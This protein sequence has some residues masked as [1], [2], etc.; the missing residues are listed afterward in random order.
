MGL[1]LGRGRR[2]AITTSFRTTACRCTGIRYAS[3]LNPADGSRFAA[4]SDGRRQ[5]QLLRCAHDLLPGASPAIQS[6]VPVI[7]PVIDYNN[8]LNHNILGGEFSY[9]SNMTS[10]SRDQRRRSTPIN[11][12]VDPYTNG[13]CRQSASSRPGWR[14]RH[15]NSCLLN[16]IPG[17]YTRVTGEAQWRRSYHRLVRPDLHAVRDPARSMRSMP[18]SPTSPASPTSCRPATRQRAGDADRRP[19]VSLSVHQRSA[20]GHHDASNPSRR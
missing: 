16:G 3:F 11:T 19:R 2:S 13:L 6:Q 14:E 4:L 20:V 17:T 1:G 5:P 12:S 10:L 8:V 9:K 15:L 7:H 18:R